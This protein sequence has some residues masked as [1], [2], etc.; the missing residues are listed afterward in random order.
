MM[1]KF[2]LLAEV[3]PTIQSIEYERTEKIP[4]VFLVQWSLKHRQIFPQ[5]IYD[6]VCRHFGL[7]DLGEGIA[8]GWYPLSR[9]QGCCCTSYSALD[10]HP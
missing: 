10:S 4:K 9:G 8:T 1:K 6:N 5:R 2:T 7:S 3:G